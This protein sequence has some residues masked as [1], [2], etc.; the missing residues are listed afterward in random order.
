MPDNLHSKTQGLVGTFFAERR[1]WLPIYP[2]FSVR[3][4]LRKSLYLV[5]DVAVFHPTEPLQPVP[6]TPPLV[7]VEV[8]SLDDKMSKVREKLAEYS[9]WGITHVWL[10]DPHSKRMYIWN[11]GLVEMSTLRIPTLRFE[12]TPADIFE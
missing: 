7:V 12:L 10:V 6:E 1:H 11:A 8:L 3:L 4:K 2:V 5:P 9:S